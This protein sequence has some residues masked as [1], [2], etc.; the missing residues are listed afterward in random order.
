VALNA[1]LGRG[2]SFLVIC[3]T[4]VFHDREL[5]RRGGVDGVSLDRT[6]D[7]RAKILYRTTFRTEPNGFLYH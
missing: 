5:P 4:D 6:V 2:R 7:L 1:S 3:G